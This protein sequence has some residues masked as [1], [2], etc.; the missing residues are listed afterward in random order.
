MRLRVLIAAAVVLV[1]SLVFSSGGASAAVAN[2]QKGV[3]I[4]S[5]YSTDFGSEMFK[6]S[7][8]N[9]AANGVNAVALIVPVHQDNIYSSSVYAGSD[10]PTDA[11]IRAALDYLK[12]MGIG[13][14]IA[15][16]DNPYDGQWRSF[17]TASD[18][19]SWFGSYSSLLNHY[20][21]IAQAGGAK[22]MIIG[23]ELSGM[24][25]IENTARWV[26][27]IASLRQQ[28]GGSLTYSAQ[29][30]GYRSDAQSLGFWPQLDAIGISAYYSLGY[31][32][33]IDA[34][35]AQWNNYNQQEVSV[36]AARYNKPVIFPEIG[37]VSRDNAINDPGSGYNLNT[38]TNPTLQAK[39]YEAFLSYW[40]SYNVLTGAYFWDWNSDPNA[41]G[42][43]DNG[44]TPQG[45]PAQ[46]IMKQYF[47]AAP[48][49]GIG[50]G[51]PSPA[52][53]PSGFSLTGDS[54]SVT[55]TSALNS[56]VS[57]AATAAYSGV[58]V[59]YEV[60]NAAGTRV[61]QSYFENQ[62]VGTT[63]NSY[64]VSWTPPTTGVYTIKGGIF[65]ANW[66]GNLYWNDSISTITV[67]TVA[68]V[69]QPQPTP[70]TPP[71][72]VTPPPVT[73]PAPTPTP[74]PTPTPV[75]TPVPA[76][77]NPTPITAQPTDIAIWWPSNGSSVSGV[78]PFKAVINGRDDVS[79][80]MFWQV[81]SGALNVMT[82]TATDGVH[83]ECAVD[84]TNWKW[85]ANHLYTINFVAKDK[86][87]NI[88]SQKAVTI[89][90][91]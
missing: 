59:D 9:A 50:A 76:P 91:Y 53:V 80:D 74:T 58:I 20:G 89:S 48:T 73:T 41:G 38:S 72:V 6:Q 14:T 90:I 60:Y 87:G 5:R 17:V 67:T 39:A 83:K 10:T 37:Y 21:M 44:Y 64:T 55:G 63:P 36:L 27:M 26:S 19:D 18:K 8:T 40:N 13:A 12:S 66:S 1:G 82:A 84:L 24:T 34:M 29:H 11:S 43:N 79:Y 42:I 3:S 16:H 15:I 68:P 35:K 31:D 69:P 4:Q 70:V 22:Q 65:K 75:P 62:T 57:A 54:V 81:D 88:I 61:A 77:T 46:A 45:K 28:F 25:G 85:N 7:V 47:T 52:P 30:A 51:T 23:T 71:V 56:Q 78:Q 49:G 86:T 32:E 33:N 2:W